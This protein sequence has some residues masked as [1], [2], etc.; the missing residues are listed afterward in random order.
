MEIR[1]VEDLMAAMND[2]AYEYERKIKANIKKVLSD[3]KYSDTGRLPT[4]LTSEV[5]ESK[6][7]EA[8][9]IIIHYEEYG[10]YI[11]V[12]KLLWTSMPPVKA[13]FGWV[14]RHPQFI[15]DRVPGY[16]D[17]YSAFRLSD[18]KIDL[19]IAWAIAVKKRK[20]DYRYKKQQWKREALPDILIEM[21][22]RI[23]NDYARNI[24]TLLSKSITR[25]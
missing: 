6:M 21:N 9:K 3:K 16:K 13:M 17:A 24:E 5:I 12:K 15:D 11:G 14:Q 25:K 22:A 20:Y 4:T 10:Y 2:V 7:G 19:R 18:D 23:M 8:P 1:N